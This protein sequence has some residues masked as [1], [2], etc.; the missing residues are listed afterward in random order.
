[1]IVGCVATLRPLF[2]RVFNLGGDTTPNDTPGV[3]YTKRPAIKTRPSGKDEEWV[4]LSDPK[5]GSMVQGRMLPDSGSE[6]YILGD[7]IKV[8]N[9]VEQSVEECK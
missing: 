5:M 1:M 4:A 2:R 6:E 9:T 7:G 8:T 3:T